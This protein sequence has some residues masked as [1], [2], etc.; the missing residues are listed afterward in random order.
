MRKEDAKTFSERLTNILQQYPDVCKEA[1]KYFENRKKT[2]ISMIVEPE[3]FES[4]YWGNLAEYMVNNAHVKGLVVEFLKLIDVSRNLRG[5]TLLTIKGYLERGNVDD[6][7]QLIDNDL[8][9]NFG[10]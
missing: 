6:A 9:T 2:T 4:R 10:V 7:L 3:E 5:I 1:A 8:N